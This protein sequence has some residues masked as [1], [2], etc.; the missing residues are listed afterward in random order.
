MTSC[1]ANLIVKAYNTV[2]GLLS[3]SYSFYLQREENHQLDSQPGNS[4][5]VP[6]AVDPG[7]KAE[8]TAGDIAKDAPAV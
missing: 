1:F 2:K 7:T 8:P 4:K 3:V 6:N 5:A